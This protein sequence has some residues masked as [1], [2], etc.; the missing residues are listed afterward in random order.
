MFLIPILSL[1]LA[2]TPREKAKLQATVSRPPP[3]TR[4]LSQTHA[5]AVQ[6]LVLW[7]LSVEHNNPRATGLSLDNRGAV[8]KVVVLHIDMFDRSVYVRNAA[9]LSFFTQFPQVSCV[10]KKF[11]ISEKCAWLLT[12]CILAQCTHHHPHT[13]IYTRSIVSSSPGTRALSARFDRNYLTSFCKLQRSF[14]AV[15]GY[16][17][18]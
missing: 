1:S 12:A 14:A 18:P 3:L 9:N 7:S 11:V 6:S 13:H 16:S 10:H 5:Q 8:A 15:C 4:C 17:N 2:H